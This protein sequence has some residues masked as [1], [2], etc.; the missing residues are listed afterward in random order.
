[1]KN[2][3]RQALMDVFINMAGNADDKDDKWIKMPSTHSVAGRDPLK[4]TEE[5]RRE[6]ARKM[7]AQAPSNKQLMNRARASKTKWWPSFGDE[8]SRIRF[9]L[10]WSVV[11]ALF[12]FVWLSTE[13]ELFEWEDKRVSAEIISTPSS[14][15][16]SEAEQLSTLT[17]VEVNQESS[18]SPLE[19]IQY[20]SDDTAL[21]ELL[22]A[23]KSESLTTVKKNKAK[24]SKESRKEAKKPKSEELEDASK[25]RKRGER[26][27]KDG[28][29]E[30]EK[31]EKDGKDERG[32]KSPKERKS[33]VNLLEKLITKSDASKKKGA[34]S[35]ESS[36]ESKRK[37]GRANR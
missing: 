20:I 23:Q 28:K 36:K 4:E 24:P 13:F 14:E 37:E 18:Y 25:R 12:F 11:V 1:M 7:L 19:A 3:P 17:S 10:T 21:P 31:P 5:G 2:D 35:K 29:D 26:P 9:H 27:E 30:R 22:S 16:Q 15:I 8:K 32:K 34:S 33:K 6:T